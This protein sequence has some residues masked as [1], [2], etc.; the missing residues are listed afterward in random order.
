MV[1]YNANIK[2][3][4]DAQD[5][6]K[7]I[8]Q[9]EDRINKLKDPKVSAAA[10]QVL[11]S[12]APE[13][14]TLKR[15]GRRL[16]V[17]V[18]LNAALTRQNTLLKNLARAGAFAA[19]GRAKEIND[20]KEVAK[21]GKNN[22]GIQNSVNSAL[23]KI[24]QEKREIN[25]TEK[26]QA[27]IAQ[28]N[29]VGGALDQ[30]IA[31][32]KA[33]GA[34]QKAL[35]NI[36]EE[37]LKLGN[38]NS[39]K[40]SDLAKTQLELVRNL[41]SEQE[42]LNSV[43]LGRPGRQLANPIRG[44]VNIPGSPKFIENLKTQGLA[45]RK[46]AGSF[47]T[48]IN[49]AAKFSS[50]GK[51][52][53]A[54]PSSK[55][56]N[57]TNRGI[58]R[59]VTNQDKVTAGYDRQFRALQRRRAREEELAAFNRRTQQIGERNAKQKLRQEN[60]VNDAL[61]KQ[62]RLRAR[63]AKAAKRTAD[64]AAR[65]AK[66]ARSKKG[67]D[68]ATGIGFPLLFGGGLGSIIGGGLGSLFGGFGGSVLGSALGQQ[69]DGAIQAANN[70][71]VEVTKA[72]TALSNLTTLLGLRGSTAVGAFS[73]AET[74]GIGSAAR[75]AAEASLETIVG[76][77]GVKN[78]EALSD[79]AED[80]GNALNRF[81]IGATAFFA[82]LLTSLNQL[83]TNLFGGTST[84]QRFKEETAADK[85]R[86]PVL[87]GPGSEARLEFD[88]A[89]RTRTEALGK[90]PEVKAQLELENKIKD[91]VEDRID[92]AQQETNL[93][94]SLLTARRDTLAVAQGDYGIS[95][96]KTKLKVVEIQL[97]GKLSDAKRR[98]LDL[99]R[100]LTKQAIERAEAAKE[101]ARI[102]AERQIRRERDAIGISIA[103]TITESFAV[104]R[105]L[106]D[107]SKSAEETFK[108][109]NAELDDQLRT[110]LDVL[111]VQK[112]LD[113]LG[114]NEE[115]LLKAITLRYNEL[116]QLELNRTA[117]KKEQVRQAEILR[118]I[119]EQRFR[120]SLTQ[121]TNDARRSAEERIRGTD[122]FRAYSFASAGL[123]FFGDSEKF[124]ADRIAAFN[125]QLERYNELIAAQQQIVAKGA[126][127]GLDKKKQFANELELERLQRARADYKLYQSQ[128]DRAAISQARFSDA[129]AA[130]S[131]GVNAIVGGL[132]DIVA[133]TKTAQEAFADFL[134]TVADQLIQTAAIMIAQYIAIGI[135]KAFAGLGS[136]PDAGDAMD[137][138]G[139]L[140]MF[141]NPNE[142]M[143]F[144]NGGYVNRPTNAI[145]GEG[146]QGEYVIPEN[147]MRESMARYSRGARGSAVIPAEGNG[148]GGGETQ[149]GT[150][151]APRIDVTYSVERI[152]EVDYVTA[153]E[154]RRGMQQAAQQGAVQGQ[155]RTLYALRQNTTQRRRIGI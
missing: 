61:G 111:N 9:L 29:K 23:E 91:V 99:E 150:A 38:L 57:A 27:R 88:V 32:L 100:E 82:P 4:L 24:L 94:K 22:L 43:A 74:L 105:Q 86:P 67:Q 62:E 93:E 16:Q 90:T 25:R 11:G 3:F 54:L 106:N 28:Q 151:V 85:A 66:A 17:Q 142:T 136:A 13:K 97:E 21:A 143:P 15:A 14:I 103:Q 70:F 71:A 1:S 51:N 112:N 126:V 49:K 30:R 121:A 63:N 18:R 132:Q 95:A 6:F 58:Q 39:T 96:Q 60:K 64:A 137:G 72:S 155:Q 138:G 73:F 122:P 133:G 92:L 42:K 44:S 110:R 78:L 46:L 109:V 102:L 147:K 140:P 104:E 89:R 79:S 12:S 116:V 125:A 59:L 130:V 117:L 50:K 45:L 19:A 148:G 115:E 128:V 124:Q 144:A 75:T 33:V 53:L 41:I 87:A 120:Q 153:E 83:V 80:A 8:K 149:S 68:I 114:K 154:F 20:L 129:L 35:L 108:A 10:K 36:E 152:N 141:A 26:E 81:S 101:N 48:I 7:Q 107:F 134:K 40:S 123:G 76:K 47:N 118:Q 2:V 5:A 65:K 84:L 31:R 56:L 55:D 146:N 113:M 52:I 131:P 37:R 119:E 98:E 69:L 77:Q 145:I 34:S 127:K 135:A 139:V